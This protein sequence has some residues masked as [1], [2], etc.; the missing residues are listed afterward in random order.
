MDMWWW[1]RRRGAESRSRCRGCRDGQ[2]G[3]GLLHLASFAR[4]S[5][6]SDNNL[7][8]HIL[9]S[10]YPDPHRPWQNNKEIS[11][12]L[13]H[14]RG[15]NSKSLQISLLRRFQAFSLNRILPPLTISTSVPTMAS[16]ANEDGIRPY[17]PSDLKQT[18]LLIGSSAMEQL[19]SA[20][21]KGMHQISQV[22]RMCIR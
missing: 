9:L 14:A 22:Y 2:E 11:L 15:L 4:F 3:P 13:F 16:S 12:F 10:A 21:Y 18:R 1:C 20:N 6:C 8:S 7:V 17:R 5:S 19:A